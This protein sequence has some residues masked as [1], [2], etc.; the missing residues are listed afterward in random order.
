MATLVERLREQVAR[1]KRE[2]EIKSSVSK[3]A[4][5]ITDT[6]ELA[7]RIKDRQAGSSTIK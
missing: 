4:S 3:V 6:A 7:K 2:A 1:Q 5:N